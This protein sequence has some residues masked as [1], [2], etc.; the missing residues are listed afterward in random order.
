MSFVLPEYQPPDFSSPE[1][2]KAPPARVEG[3]PADGVAPADFHGTSNHPEYVR[4]E[5]GEWVLASQ[6]RMDC[7]PPAAQWC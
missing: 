7:W 6:N 4:R 3:A 2:A 1:L 5:S